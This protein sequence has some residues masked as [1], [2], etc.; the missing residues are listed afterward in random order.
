M[1]I[2]MPKKKPPRPNLARKNLKEIKRTVPLPDGTTT[3]KSFYGKTLPAAQ[4]SYL[5]FLNPALKLD[6]PSGSLAW[7]VINKYSPL[8]SH[9]AKSTR[10]KIQSAS[11]HLLQELGDMPIAQLT[12]SNLCQALDAIA[13]KQTC[14]N[15]KAKGEKIMRPLGANMVNQCRQIA[16]ECNE[17]ASE[18]D[19]NIRK[20]NRKRVPVR[21]EE[22]PIVDVFTP[23]EMRLLLEGFRGTPWMVPLIL[24]GYCGLRGREA[25]G[26]EK[27]DLSAAGVLNIHQQGEGQRAPWKLKNRYSYRKLP[28]PDGMLEEL[29]PYAFGDGRLCQNSA[30]KKLPNGTKVPDP[31]P[32]TLS[33]FDRALEAKCR[34]IGLP[35]LTTHK[36]RHSF[37]TWLDENGCPRSVRLA[38]MGQSTKAV[39]DRY[40][41]ASPEKMREWLGKLWEASYEEVDRELLPI[42]PGASGNPRKESIT[43]EAN[44]RSVLTTADVCTIRE[45]AGE[46][47]AAELSRRF[48]VSRKTIS[49]ITTGKTWKRTA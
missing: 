28:L 17:L 2:A 8:K 39:Q 14:R 45:L 18:E 36:L 21:D 13:N 19:P 9:L 7:W 1:Q 44:G 41:H 20:I 6:T 22:V 25:I 31:K 48:G 15:P 5:E 33:G 32:I 42:A 16:L 11:R 27:R 12:A 10:V 47:S 26:V 49:N 3:R 30:V 46:V 43:G 29:R 24:Y 40:N 4:R 37:S 34:R 35:P 38:L 23:A